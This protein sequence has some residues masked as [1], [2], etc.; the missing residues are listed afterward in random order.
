MARVG[1][2]LGNLGTWLDGENPGAGS[3]TVD[4]TG[5]NGN[6]IKLDTGVFT[7]H[8]T[9]GAHKT[10]VI[11]GPNLKTT[12][13]DASTIE[14]AG[15][16]LKLN[17]KALGIGTAQIAATTITAAKLANSCIDAAAKIVDGVITGAKLAASTITV[18]QLANDAVETAK[19]KDAN[20]TTAKFEYKEYV[21]LITQTGTAD[22]VATVIKNTLSAG[23]VWTRSAVGDYVGTLASAFTSNKTAFSVTGGAFNGEH[24]GMNWISA[25]GM[26]L[27]SV[28]AAGTKTDA[29]LNG[30]SVIIRVYP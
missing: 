30:C 15:A 7:E 25:N 14:L 24:Y 12:V 19:I 17:V 18:T 2:P 5:L 4:N 23:I 11:D 13:A 20:V 29:L 9:A 6:W 3:Q 8:T 10:N 26:A 28:N 22:P 16:P 21:A 1:T 27:N